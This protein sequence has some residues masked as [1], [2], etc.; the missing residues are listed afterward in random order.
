[1][2]ENK[3]K[4]AIEGTP[5][6]FA[7]SENDRQT[8]AMVSQ[9]LDQKRVKLAFQPVVLGSD[10]TRV[11]FHEG[12]I[13]ILD[14]TG[15]VIPARDFMAA[16][17]EQET[18][19]RIDVAALEAGLWTL[20]QN[21]TLRLAVNMSARSVGYAPWMRALRHGLKRDATVGERLILEITES[22]A[23]LVP[24]LVVSFMDE[25][26][27][28]GIAFALDD[29]GAGFTAFRYFK[30]F[31]FDMVK[32]DGQFVRGIARDP[33]NQVLTRALQSIAQQ[34]EMVTVAESVET[35][36]E[37]EFLRGIGID[38]LQGYLFGAPTTKPDWSRDAMSLSA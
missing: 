3:R 12:L 25:L 9:A 34:F 8:L 5:L 26:Q 28:Y 37:A 10:P 14:P 21:P 16:V 1:M 19:R 4:A 27:Q 2:A 17:E 38:C 13:R 36:A 29:F 20:S 15:R 32:I 33:D 31:F 35:V 7:I 23:M 22:S 24:E 11:A 18:G 6:G 30:D